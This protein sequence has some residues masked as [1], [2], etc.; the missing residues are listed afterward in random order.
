MN[1]GLGKQLEYADTAR[2][3]FVL[4]VGEKELKKKKFKLRDMK[5]KSEKELSLDQIIK[6]LNKSD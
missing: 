6:K 4:I 5:K 3:P 1:R 2:I